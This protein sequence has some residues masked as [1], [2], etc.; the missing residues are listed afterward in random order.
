MALIYANSAF[1]RP[2]SENYGQALAEELKESGYIQLATGK[3]DLTA[4]IVSGGKDK[5]GG[6]DTIRVRYI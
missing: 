3:K 2:Y 4:V 5:I 1:V 6:T